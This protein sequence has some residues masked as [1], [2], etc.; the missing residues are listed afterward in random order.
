MKKDVLIKSL[1]F[2]IEVMEEKERVLNVFSLNKDI[3]EHSKHFTYINDLV[4]FLLYK[5]QILEDIIRSNY[6]YVINK[7]I[8]DVFQI[9]ELKVA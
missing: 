7:L 4:E 3:L 9:N 8:N 6:L 5:W 1:Q 2:R